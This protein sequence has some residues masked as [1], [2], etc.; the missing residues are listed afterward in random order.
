MYDWTVLNQTV[1]ATLASGQVGAPVFVRWTAAA[2]QEQGGREPLFRH[3]LSLFGDLKYPPDF[4]HF[5]YVN[6]AAPKGGLVRRGIVGTFDNFNMVVSGVKG[7][8]AAG[9]GLQ[10]D[11]D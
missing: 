4:K 8:L 7:S 6:P 3:G 5:D 2:A 10:V 9:V 11:R 1:S